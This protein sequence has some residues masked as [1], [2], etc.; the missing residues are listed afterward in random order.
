VRWPE[1][2]FVEEVLLIAVRE[3][4]DSCFSAHGWSYFI[5]QSHSVQEGIRTLATI[6]ARA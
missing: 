3:E 1:W 5:G 4:Q 6:V 2:W